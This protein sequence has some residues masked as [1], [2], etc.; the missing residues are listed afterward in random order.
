MSI[1]KSKKILNWLPKIEFKQGLEMIIKKDVFKK[2]TYI[3]AEAG[4]NHNGNFLIAKKFIRSAKDCGADAIKFQSFIPEEVV[5]K[6]L[7]LANYQKKNL[8]NKKI[9]MLDMIRRY[10]L[11]MNK[12]NFFSICK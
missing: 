7:N 8:K 11:R 4:I 1:K 2:R 5:T 3:I 12:L 10:S 9:K 6:N